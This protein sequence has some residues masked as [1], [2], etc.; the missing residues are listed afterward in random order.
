[1]ANMPGFEEACD[2]VHQEKFADHVGLHLVLRDGF[3]LTEPIKRV[4]AFCDSNGRLSRLT[5]RPV[6]SLSSQ[7]KRAL[8]EEI[9]AQIT[10]CRKFG[11][12][13]LTHV[14]SHCHLHTNFTVAS[15]LLTVMAE[16]GLNCL[17]ISRNCGPINGMG[18][19][20]YKNLFN[21]WLRRKGVA[22]TKY[23]G[24]VADV[25]DSFNGKVQSGSKTSVEIMI[26]PIL[27]SQGRTVDRHAQCAVDDL[28]KKI[29][30]YHQA[31]SFAGRKYP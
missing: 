1:M 30:G 26:H 31:V 4:P 7:E 11:H 14:D 18:R 27:D 17:R 12:L 23:F 10:R 3:P 2:L 21:A 15:V 29:T 5:L 25:V 16:Q 9:R 24:S 19:R 8:A 13:P 22:A 28:V 6:M 20:L